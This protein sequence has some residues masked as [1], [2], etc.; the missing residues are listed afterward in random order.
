M[1]RAIQ[2]YEKASAG[3]IPR[4]EAVSSAELY[5]PVDHLLSQGAKRVIDIGAGTGRDAA[6]FADRGQKVLAVEPVSQLR[7]A[8]I[9]LHPSPNIQWLDDT[10]PTLPHVLEREEK[11]DLLVLGAIWHHLDEDERRLTMPVLRRLTS[12]D[13]LLIMSLRH[14][15]GTSDRPCFE[16]DPEQVIDLALE[17]GFRSIFRKSA[18]SIQ[19]RNKTAEVTWTW[20]A[21]APTA[22]DRPRKNII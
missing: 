18:D 15:P 1:S 7:E 11:F 22:Q 4:F 14:G 20:L 19:A 3:L 9:K 2:G 5:T 21:F 8:G 17:Q 13:G 6:W 10:L 16:S 12:A